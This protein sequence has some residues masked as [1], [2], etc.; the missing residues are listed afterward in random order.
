MAAP[1]QE[2]VQVTVAATAALEAGAREAKGGGAM[3]RA[4]MAM[5]AVAVGAPGQETV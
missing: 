5:A 4:G 3:A 1:G 2:T